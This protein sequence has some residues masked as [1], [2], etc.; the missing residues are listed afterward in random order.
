MKLSLKFDWFFWLEVWSC[1]ASSFWKTLNL[2]TFFFFFFFLVSPKWCCVLESITML[3]WSKEKHWKR[4]STAQLFWDLKSFVLSPWK[5]CSKSWAS[6]AMQKVS[7]ASTFVFLVSLKYWTKSVAYLL[8]W[9]AVV[10]FSSL[11]SPSYIQVFL[12]WDV[13][14][15]FITCVKRTLF[16][17]IVSFQ[18]AALKIR[19]NHLR[20]FLH[21]TLQSSPFSNFWKQQ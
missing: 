19:A 18:E 3:W 17:A 5:L 8:R 20:Y 10:A 4:S 11:F 15:I 12:E 9:R 6:T 1:S 21:L 16:S 13:S 14:E 2:E 7:Q